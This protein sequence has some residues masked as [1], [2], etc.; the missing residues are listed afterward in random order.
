MTLT[1]AEVV[2]A[3][4]VLAYPTLC[5]TTNDSVKEKL[6]S[7]LLGH[8]QYTTE[9]E[10]HLLFIQA[11]RY[12]HG[13]MRTYSNVYS[14]LKELRGSLHHNCNDN[15]DYVLGFYESRVKN[16]V[17]CSSRARWRKLG[18]YDLYKSAFMFAW[19]SEWWRAV[20]VGAHQPIIRDTVKETIDGYSKEV[21]YPE[22]YFDRYTEEYHAE[23]L[24]EAYENRDRFRSLL[25]ELYGEGCFR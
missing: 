22:W 14:S 13:S 9:E 8:G 21:V 3:K 17:R 24:S 15:L 6:Y 12:N 2:I 20:R 23:L 10:P 5:N 16:I 7:W 19:K 11:R 4:D 25:C 1:P 18:W